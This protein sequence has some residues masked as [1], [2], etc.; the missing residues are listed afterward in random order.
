MLILFSCGSN[1]LKI[2]SQKEIYSSVKVREYTVTTNLNFNFINKKE[3]I[4]GVFDYS[5]L[6]GFEG[7]GIEFF[8]N[9]KFETRWYSCTERKHDFLYKSKGK[10]YFKED[11]LVLKLGFPKFR[12]YYFKVIHFDEAN[13]LVSNKKWL[14]FNTFMIEN[15]KLRDILNGCC[16]M[17]DSTLR[18]KCGYLSEIGAIKLNR[19]K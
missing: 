11:N 5:I 18:R 9:G 7:I 15:K 12:K 6:T 16:V 2:I 19:T 3:D 17:E 10:W 1:D 4:I 13:I 14:K 8:E